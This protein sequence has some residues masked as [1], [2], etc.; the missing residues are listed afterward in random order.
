MK[1]LIFAA[2]GAKPEIVLDDALNNDLRIVKHEANCLIY[3]RPLAAHGLT[4]GQL[5]SWWDDHQGL[6]GQPERAIW[7]SLHRRLLASIDAGQR[8]RAA[9]LQRLRQALCR[10]RGGPRG[11]DPQ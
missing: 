8:H 10:V 4:W 1:N 7:R 3:D 11:P 2:L 9:H 5:T 6:T